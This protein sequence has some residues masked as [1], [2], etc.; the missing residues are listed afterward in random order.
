MLAAV[1]HQG[2]GP[3]VGLCFSAQRGWDLQGLFNLPGC[4]D[5]CFPLI[6]GGQWRPT[7][8]GFVDPR[9]RVR[10]ERPE[11]AEPQSQCYKSVLFLL[12]GKE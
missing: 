12:S 7:V 6:Q 11:G 3:G 10:S 8:S 4:W 9:Q 1:A 2:W 5:L